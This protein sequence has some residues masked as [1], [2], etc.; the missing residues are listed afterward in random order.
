MLCIMRSLGSLSDDLGVGIHST[1]MSRD[2]T[3]TIRTGVGHYI[4][5]AFS[6]SSHRSAE[7]FVCDGR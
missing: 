3:G 6:D 2:G 5:A 7:L 1:T 4:V